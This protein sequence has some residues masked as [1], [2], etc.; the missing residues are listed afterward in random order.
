[1][2]ALH[3]GKMAPA[4]PAL[5]AELGLDLVQGGF[6]VSAFY[7]V[8]ITLAMVVGM[9][10]DRWDRRAMMVAGFALM[11]LGG[12]IGALAPELGWLLAGRVL[13]GLGFVAV[14]VAA[15]SIV[16]SAS[17]SADQ[18][19]TLSLWSIFL[20]T[21]VALSLLA[22]PQVLPAFGWRGLWEGITLLALAALAW[23]MVG[24]RGPAA[25]RPAG[26]RP[27]TGWNSALRAATHPGLLLLGLAFGAYAFQ[28]VSFMIWLPTFLAADMGMADG[29]AARMTALVVAANVPGNILGGVLLRRGGRRDMTVTCASLAMALCAAGIFASDLPQGAR[30]ALCV[31]FSFAGGFIPSALFAGAAWHARAAGGMS[32]ASGLLMQGSNIGQFVGPPTLAASVAAAGGEWATALWPMLCGAGLAAT[33]ALAARR[34]ERRAAG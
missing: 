18:P 33:A 16:Q 8:S 7:L 12:T 24:L 5:R 29:T 25:A 4:L 19:L 11:A 28:W 1:M 3:V 13:E 21:G 2:A 27:P 30:Y 6:A 32:A 26:W 15:P 20:P 9:A 10:A 22:A 23:T 31:V 14:V 17:A 34:L